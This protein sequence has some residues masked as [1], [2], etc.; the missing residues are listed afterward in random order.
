MEGGHVAHAKDNKQ[1]CMLFFPRKKKGKNQIENLC[2]SERRK[3]KNVDQTRR[4]WA[5]MNEQHL[6]AVINPPASWSCLDTTHFLFFSR[7]FEWNPPHS[8]SNFCRRSC[9]ERERVLKNKICKPRPFLFRVSFV[10]VFDKETLTNKER[11][12]WIDLWYDYCLTWF[13][14]RFHSFFFV[15]CFFFDLQSKMSSSDQ[16]N[17]TGSSMHQKGKNR[18]WLTS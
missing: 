8:L 10:Q 13:Q 17:S 9:I 12:K 16:S 14:A 4:L 6:H 3:Y 7:S 15:V 5:A 1:Q 2:F 18:N 11:E